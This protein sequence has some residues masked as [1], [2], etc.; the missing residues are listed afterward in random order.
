[1]KMRDACDAAV[2]A[3]VELR[4]VHGQRCRTL[5]PVVFQ[6]LRYEMADG[7]L[8]FE[9]RTADMRCQDHIV[10]VSQRRG[11]RIAAL[12]RLDREHVN[13]RPGDMPGIQMALERVQIR[14]KTA[15]QVDE[16]SALLHVGELFLAEEASVRLAPVHM[17][18]HGIGLLKELIETRHALGVAHRELL[19][20]IIEQDAH[21]HGLG[22]N[23]K[24]GADIAVADDAERLAA[25]LVRPAGGLVPHAML[26]MVRVCRDAAHQADDVADDQFHHGTG[27]RI[28][29]VEH[30]DAALARVVEIDLVGADAEA[31][32]RG[33][34]GTGVDH[35]ASDIRL[36][37]NAQ[38]INTFERVDELI[39]AQSALERFHFKTVV[40][41]RLRRERMNIL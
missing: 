12:L 39:L 9:R 6:T 31:A 20:K 15:R 30:G 22:E 18:R 28:R 2:V 38:Q 32:D 37:A 36:G 25:H 26:H 3:E 27:I 14:N 17:Q 41:Q 34:V 23:R 40:S 21:A 13:G 35:L 8:S 29:R 10:L 11:E 19:L 7:F 5:E 33:Q 4:E 24:L 1:M 16:N